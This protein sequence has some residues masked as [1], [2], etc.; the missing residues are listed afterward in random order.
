MAGETTVV[1]GGPLAGYL[2]FGLGYGV[3]ALIAYSTYA[4]LYMYSQGSQEAKDTALTRVATGTAV[5]IGAT[6]IGQGGNM[7]T[8]EGGRRKTKKGKRRSGKTRRR[9]K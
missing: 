4:S 6:G 5:G 2:F 1:N 9:H 8:S 3:L 7:S